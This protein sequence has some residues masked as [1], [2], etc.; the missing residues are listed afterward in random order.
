MEITLSEKSPSLVISSDPT[1][2]SEPSL[3][4]DPNPEPILYEDI[5]LSSELKACDFKSG[6]ADPRSDD[7]LARK[8]LSLYDTKAYCRR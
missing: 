3:S 1:L 6:L 8:F 5:N 7:D 2:S 4:T